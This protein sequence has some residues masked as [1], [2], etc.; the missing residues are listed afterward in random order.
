CYIGM[1]TQTTS[2]PAASAIVPWTAPADGTLGL[3]RCT[4]DT[5][6]GGTNYRTFDVQV[7]GSDALGHSCVISGSSTT[8]SND[9]T[10]TNVRAGDTVRIEVS[11]SGAA[12]TGAGCTLEFHKA[13]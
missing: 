10:A 8:C 13:P 2:C 11:R 7:N 3:L 4:V 12:A 9:T 1:G 5:A 6:P